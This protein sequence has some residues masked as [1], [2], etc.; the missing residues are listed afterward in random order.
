MLE[1]VK[2]IWND[3]DE[4]ITL[5]QREL[6]LGAAVC[7]L[8]G[9]LAGMLL[10]PKGDRAAW[11]DNWCDNGNNYPAPPKPPRHDPCP[12]DEEA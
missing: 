6:V 12:D 8:A 5:N 2:K 10:S 1:N 7:T 4:K 9:M 3:L 11:C